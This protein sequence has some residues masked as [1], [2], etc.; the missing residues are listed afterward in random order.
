LLDFI[1]IAIPAGYTFNAKHLAKMRIQNPPV[2]PEQRVFNQRLPRDF[3]AATL[4][5]WHK[6]SNSINK[7]DPPQWLT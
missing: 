3:S 2:F 1:K 7:K 4:T 5:P 6:P